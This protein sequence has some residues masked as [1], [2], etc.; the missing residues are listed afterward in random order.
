MA[1]LNIKYALYIKYAMD[2][3]MKTYVTAINTV[4]KKCPLKDMSENLIVCLI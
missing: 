1:Y 4:Q 2:E 3:T